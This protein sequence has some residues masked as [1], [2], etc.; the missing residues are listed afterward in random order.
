MSTFEEDY[1]AL[2]LKWNFFNESSIRNYRIYKRYCQLNYVEH[3][4]SSEAF[5][6]I[7]EEFPPI[8]ASGIQK[9]VYRM[10]RE[11][12]SIRAKSSELQSKKNQG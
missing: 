7:A 12:E 10:K 4:K 11:D 6:I 8:S 5:E 3:V 1:I 9:I 2:G